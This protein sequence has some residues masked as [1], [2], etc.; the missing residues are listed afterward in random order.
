MVREFKLLNEKNQYY[1]LMD[2]ENYCFLSEPSGLGYGY[3][4]E[5]EQ[6][7]N[8]FII[9]IRKLEQGEISGI[10]NF[11]NYENYKKL[12]DFIESSK[13]LKIAYKVPYHNNV[14]EFF[15]DV[16]INQIS[17]TE[18]S[19]NGL[20]SEDISF[21][22]LGLWY[23]DEVTQYDIGDLWE[24]EMQWDF[25]WDTRFGDYQTRIIDFENDGQTEAPFK[26]EID[27]IIS[28]PSISIYV[29]DVIVNQITIPVEIGY[30]EKLQYSSVDNNLYLRK[31]NS[32][33]T[34]T[35]LFKNQYVDLR[36]NNIF[37]IPKGKSTISVSSSDNILAGKLDIYKQ[38]KAV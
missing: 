7:N 22:C 28:N 36:N 2:I 26:L 34:Y 14:T 25:M 9:G 19:Q 31:E 20:I 1:S 8:S 13:E 15:R 21:N 30:G 4:T 32:N 37:K 5:Y 10:A 35:N 23:K 33:G 3:E 12:I 29:D 38:Y 16:Q 24:T 18:I 27:G 11:K 17:K 6:L